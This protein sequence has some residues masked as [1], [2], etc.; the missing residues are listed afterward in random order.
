MADRICRAILNVADAAELLGTTG[1]AVRQRQAR[2]L[3][4]FRKIGNRV[5]FLKDEL[6]TFL[7]H[8][9]GCSLDEAKRNLAE[10]NDT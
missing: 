1:K 3:L 4:P 6:E 10:R 8:L 5:I 9:P 2:R 7:R